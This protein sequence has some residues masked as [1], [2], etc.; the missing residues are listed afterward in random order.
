M[1]YHFEKAKFTARMA[2]T[3]AGVDDCMTQEASKC[4]VCTSIQRH[5]EGLEDGHLCLLLA[6]LSHVHVG[7]LGTQQCW[8]WLWDVHI[9][10]DGCCCCCC[11]VAIA[12]GDCLAQRDC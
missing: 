7:I 3:W 10:L 2:H 1:R 8:G 11:A 5:G 12:G 6:I 4:N 9:D